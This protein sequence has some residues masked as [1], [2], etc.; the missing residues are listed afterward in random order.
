MQGTLTMLAV[1]LLSACGDSGSLGG[2]SGTPTGDGGSADGGASDGGTP[3]GGSTDGGSPDGGADGGM[4]DGGSADGGS[5]DGGTADGGSADGGSADG[6]TSDGGSG[7]GGTSDGGSG[8]GGALALADLPAGG[9][10]ISEA[11]IWTET[12]FEGGQWIEVVN[13]AGADVDLDGLVVGGTDSR[14]VDGSTI[15]GDGD[16]VVIGGSDRAEITGGTPV[17]IALGDDFVLAWEDETWTLSLSAAGSLIDAVA[18]D[19]SWSTEWGASYNLDPAHV[20]VDDNDLSTSW[21]AA[22]S[23]YGDRELRGTP[24]AANDDCPDDDDGDGWTDDVDCDDADPTVYP[25][26]ADSPYDGVDADCAG[27]SDYDADG[28]GFDSDDY[29]GADCDD[30][31]RFVRPDATDIP[32]D[33]VD[34]D[35]DGADATGDPIL[36]VTDLSAG[37]LV[38]SEVM[39][40]PAH[41][42]PEGWWVEV[43]VA[44]SDPVLFDGVVLRTEWGSCEA[45]TSTVVEAGGWF[46]FG[47]LDDADRTGVDVDIACSSLFLDELY[48]SLAV[49]DGSS[50]IDEVLFEGDYELE[51][52]SAL[53]VRPDMLN[54]TDN[55]D[56]SNWCVAVDTYGLGDHGTPGAENTCPED[57][58]LDGYDTR[59][60]CDDEDP[61]VHPGATETWYDGVDSD[62]LGDS[63]YDADGDGW[64]SDAYGGTDCDDADDSVRPDAFDLPDD[65]IDQDCDGSDATGFVVLTV[66][67]LA[68]GDLVITEL[69][70]WPGAVPDAPW[71][72][73]ENLTGEAVLLEDLRIDTLEGWHNVSSA[74]VVEA[75][76]RVVFG[77]EADLDRNGGVPVDY[78]DAELWL[79]IEESG[80]LT[81]RAGRTIVDE[82]SWSMDEWPLDAGA[83]MS[84][85]PTH[86]DADDND[87]PASWCLGADS[88]GDGDLGSP[89]ELNPSC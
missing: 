13:A 62:C 61:D 21:C 53:G 35:C 70:P 44:A 88:F 48:G 76:D 59:S 15:L 83:S 10:V 86:T 6:G 68:A 85:D 5:G 81:L 18:M 46:L 66:D 58:D 67:D 9:L 79:S 89:G 36:G 25:G 55:D 39:G 56:L 26:A 34:A 7:D 78:A 74:L 40:W 22:T 84:L 16:R 72:E 28:D 87:D 3:D 32:G 77:V 19:W 38:L 47:G 82:V 2:D 52:G 8:D 69:M 4:A 23:S 24:G 30:T 20:D 42:D 60:D 49:T 75:D 17:D 63:D 71:F 54:A 50:T 29:G 65:G 73:V 11:M 12:A 57:L 1:M 51:W 27:D 33:G 64:D 37:D 14:R 41:A 31:D 80:D 43:Y 45:V